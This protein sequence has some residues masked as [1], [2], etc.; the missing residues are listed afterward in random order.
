LHGIAFGCATAA[1]G[2]TSEF[3]EPVSAQAC[4]EFFSPLA[5]RQY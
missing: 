4:L 2:N 5:M 1:A 3:S